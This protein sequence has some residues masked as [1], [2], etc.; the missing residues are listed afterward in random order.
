MKFIRLSS[1]LLALILAV[2]RTV[3][4]LYCYDAS[5]GYFRDG[6][7]LPMIANL[8]T[9]L[10]IPFCLSLPMPLGGGKLRM[11]PARFHLPTAFSSALVAFLLIAYAAL[12]VTEIGAEILRDAPTDA[13]IVL[14]SGVSALLS[15]CGAVSFILTASMGA[16][17]SPKKAISTASVVLFAVMYALFLYFD[18][19]MPINAP[20]K[21][22]AQI[23]LLS[24]A[25]FFLYETRVALGQPMPA[26]RA[27]FG[28]LAMILTASSALPNIIYYAVHRVALLE[29]PVHDFLILA[30]FFYLAARLGS[31]LPRS[32][33]DLPPFFEAELAGEEESVSSVGQISFFTNDP[34]PIPASTSDDASPLLSSELAEASSDPESD[35][36]KSLFGAPESANAEE[37]AS[38]GDLLDSIAEDLL[39]PL[40]GKG[41][42][43]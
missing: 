41:G 29:T 13:R 19:A 2:L 40:D 12:H 36:A 31:I 7:L 24:V 21:L 35:E 10:V 20:E 27:A 34:S 18:N 43:S 28:L 37:T 15:V 1:L 9:L 4:V 23:T 38:E 8:L 14:T 42:Q 11:M 33:N 22:L 32:G 25:V 17:I 3:A 26:L 6:Y 16:E 39:G 30:F 5:L